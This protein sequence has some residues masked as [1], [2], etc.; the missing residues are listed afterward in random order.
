MPSPRSCPG[1][2]V[3][4]DLQK[5]RRIEKIHKYTSLKTIILVDCVNHSVQLKGMILATEQTDAQ[6]LALYLDEHYMEKLSLASIS[7]H[8]L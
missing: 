8:L 3:D 7:R 5:I 1:F 6:K 2:F 4:F